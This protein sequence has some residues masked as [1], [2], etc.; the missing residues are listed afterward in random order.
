MTKEEFD[1]YINYDT[2]GKFKSET[3]WYSIEEYVALRP[4]QYSYITEN[5]KKAMTQGTFQ[6]CHG[7]ILDSSKIR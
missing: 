4:K 3:N 7:E 2:P 5:G 1:I 6:E